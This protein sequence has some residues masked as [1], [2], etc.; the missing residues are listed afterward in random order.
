MA[1][2]F[3][4]RVFVPLFV[5]GPLIRDSCIRVPIRGWPAIRAQLPSSPAPRQGA[6]QKTWLPVLVDVDQK[7][8][9][10]IAVRCLQ[11]TI[12]VYFE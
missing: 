7:A 8:L 12:D 4:I 2:S 6:D 9:H 3:V 11:V 5:D 1:R 10:R